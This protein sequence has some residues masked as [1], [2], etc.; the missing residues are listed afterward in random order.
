MTKVVSVY[1][2]ETNSELGREMADPR[3][4]DTLFHYS[5]RPGRDTWCNLIL[6][7]Q[8]QSR[9]TVSPTAQARGLI[10]SGRGFL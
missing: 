2:F 7:N 6:P 5:L 9:Q 1:V 10:S 8:A 3:N 4:G